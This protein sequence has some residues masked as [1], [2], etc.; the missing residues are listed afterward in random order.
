MDKLLGKLLARLRF[1]ITVTSY[2][3]Q[4]EFAS[5]VGWSIAI[6]AIGDAVAGERGMQ[7]GFVCAIVNTLFAEFIV[8]GHFKR[9]FMSKEA[10]I[11]FRDFVTDFLTKVVPG[12]IYCLVKIGG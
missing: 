3:E 1:W 11:E 2:T 8:D 7:V 9:I 6:P 5:H 4:V 10:R 12:A